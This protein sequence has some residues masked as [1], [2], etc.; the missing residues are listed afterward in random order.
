MRDPRTI[1]HAINTGGTRAKCPN[2]AP[3]ECQQPDKP[4]FCV[5]INEENAFCHRC[6]KNWWFNDK[7]IHN[8]TEYT[9]VNTRSPLYEPSS[10][11]A[12]KSGYENA[13]SNYLKFYSDIFKILKLPWN[14]KSL[15]DHLGIG[16]QTGKDGNAQLM[17][18]IDQ[19]H[20]KVHKGPQYGSK[21]K[22][23]I[24]PSQIPETN[25]GPLLIVEGEKDAISAHCQGLAAITFTS[26]AGAIPKD[27]SQ[28][29]GID[30]IVIVYDSDEKGVE[31]AAKVAK[32][33][34]TKDRTIRILQW[35]NKPDGFDLTDY[36]VEGYNKNDLLAIIDTLP[37][38]G[39]VAEDFG[40]A[41]VMNPAEFMAKFNNPPEDIC[42]QILFECG[43]AG[44]AAATN[45]GKSVW[46]L[47]FAA[48]VAMGVPFLGH[49]RVPKPR[50]VLYMQYEMLDDVIGERLA[51]QTQPLIEQYPVEA[52]LLNENLRVSVNGQKDLFSD[53]Y[54]MVE[55]NLQHGDY[56]LIVIDNLYSSSNID[57]IKNSALISLLSRITM[58]KN[59][60]KCA[61]LMVNH[62]KKQNEVAALDPAL[63][64]GGSAYTNWLDNLVQL[65]STAV[66]PDL[67]VM[68]IT[69]V[70]KKAD[71]H[72]IPTGLKFH[73]DEGL[74]MEYLRPL[75]KNEMFWYT[76][77]KES[78][79]DRV[80]NAVLTDGDHFTV[81][82]FADAL[83]QVLNITSTRSVYKW[84]DKMIDQGLIQKVERGHYCKISTSLDDF[85]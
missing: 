62:H 9:L 39:K 81:E 58:L 69:K 44:V 33:L 20:V 67:K 22:C 36:F 49:F 34:W 73:R 57:S 2:D 13:R 47:Q 74:M 76:S 27:Y 5:Q 63:V 53:S 28:L 82:R 40:G 16:V 10:G 68:K 85:I 50:K 31:G 25:G 18:K 43:T 15:D 12:D 83:E 71:L 45:V 51:L 38:F 46:A 4:D 6:E 23:K 60:Y 29:D 78:E 42:D 59:K 30:D 80:L 56:E 84:L 21:I 52:Y 61:V 11:A 75:P 77:Q 17:F 32:K 35:E 14:D 72:W 55:G 3:P 54:N 1:F 37:R 7:N 8:P 26:G 65:A 70:R 19:N 64:F 66:S 79:M 24:Y 48:C 41:R